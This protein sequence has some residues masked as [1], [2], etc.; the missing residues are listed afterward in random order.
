MEPVGSLPHS[1]VPATCPILNQFDQSMAPRPTSWRSVLILSSH[2]S[3]GLPSGL[4][5]SGFPT[6]TL[7]KCYIPRPSHSSRFDHPNNT[8]YCRFKKIFIRRC[9]TGVGLFSWLL[10]FPFSITPPILRTQSFIYLR[11]YINLSNHHF[12]NIAYYE[13]NRR[14]VKCTNVQ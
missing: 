12:R 4:F 10:V 9:R 2:T 7:Y 13:E 14:T 5:P 11:S 8:Y 6:K 3:L 1:Q